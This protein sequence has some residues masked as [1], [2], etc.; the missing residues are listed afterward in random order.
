MRSQCIPVSFPQAD[1][2]GEMHLPAQ[3]LF[4]RVHELLPFPGQA[5]AQ[6]HVRWECC[7]HGARG[8][9]AGGPPCCSIWVLCRWEKEER[10]RGFLVTSGN[11][12]IR[13]FLGLLCRT[14][15]SKDTKKRYL[16][17]VSIVATECHNLN[18]GEPNTRNV[19]NR[20]EQ[21]TNVSGWGRLRGACWGEGPGWAVVHGGGQ[22]AEGGQGPVGLP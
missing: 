12:F 15:G 18:P 5:L 11:I 20:D 13:W 17:K 2:P 21:G 16:E 6:A 10:D 4:A 7:S 19:Q 8:R 3:L 9:P 1:A 22:G 14:E